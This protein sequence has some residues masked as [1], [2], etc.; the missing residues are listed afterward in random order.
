MGTWSWMEPALGTASFTLLAMQL[1]RAQML[2]MGYKPYT[3]MMQSIR[4]NRLADIYSQYDKDLILAFS[5]TS[6]LKTTDC[7]LDPHAAKLPS[8]A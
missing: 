3:A 8:K 5:I 6:S 4:G 7:E 2:N 1:M